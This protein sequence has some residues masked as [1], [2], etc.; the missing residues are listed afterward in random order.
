MQNRLS[1]LAR[2]ASSWQGSGEASAAG[3]G[4]RKGKKNRA[5]SPVLVSEGREAAGTET[6]S[7]WTGEKKTKIQ[8]APTSSGDLGG[9]EKIEGLDWDKD[10]LEKEINCCLERLHEVLPYDPDDG[11]FCPFDEQQLKALNERLALCRIRA[12]EHCQGA[13]DASLTD[14]YPTSELEHNGYYKYYERYFEWYFDPQYWYADFQDYQRLVLRENNGEYE[15]WE[16]YHKTCSKLEGDQQFVQLWDELSSKTKLI[17]LYLSRSSKDPKIEKLVFYHALKIAEG[18]PHVSKTLVCSTF[19]DF[20]WGVRFKH[21]W[22]KYYAGFFFEMW[23][24]TTKRKMNFIEALRHIHKE[25]KYSCCSFAWQL[26]ID[27]KEPDL[28]IFEQECKS[29][30]D[31][32]GATAEDN[33]AYQLIMDFIEEIVMKPKT[34]YDYA[35]KK[36]HIAKEIELIPY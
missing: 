26:Q 20:I 5:P 22:Y 12:Y 1:D 30:L 8:S 17:E 3:G 2:G 35:K 32:I 13:E 6:T 18:L 19:Y 4:D 23:Q 7:A 24:L 34:Y 28:S 10:Y 11:E 21:K 31:R 27:K 36:L 16:K 25:D 14:K 33:E 9:T 29:Y 15:D